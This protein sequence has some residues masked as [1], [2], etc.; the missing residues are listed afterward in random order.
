MNLPRSRMIAGLFHLFHRLRIVPGIGH[1]FIHFAGHYKHGC[2]A[3]CFGLVDAQVNFIE[4]PSLYDAMN[5]NS[6]GFA[7]LGKLGHIHF[8]VIGFHTVKAQFFQYLQL[9]KRRG[10]FLNHAIL[11]GFLN[12]S[13]KLPGVGRLVRVKHRCRRRGAGCYHEVPAVHAIPFYF[14]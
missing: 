2:C 9:F 1:V 6:C 8:L 11:D 4:R 3:D 7:C 13:G 14:P 5:N 12:L 10:A